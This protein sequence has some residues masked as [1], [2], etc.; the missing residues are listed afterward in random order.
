M[1]VASLHRRM[2]DSVC[3][4]DEKET[5]EQ[6]QPD[7]PYLILTTWATSGLGF[8]YEWTCVLRAGR[9]CAQKRER[10]E[11]TRHEGRKDYDR[12]EEKTVC[13]GEGMKKDAN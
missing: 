7:E 2:R 9:M 5:S 3:G 8:M 6:E 4:R 10:N 13:V 1:T 11:M 12:K